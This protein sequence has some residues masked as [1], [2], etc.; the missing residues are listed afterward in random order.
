MNKHSI[1]NK[2]TT[3]NYKCILRVMRITVFLFFLS[4]MFSQASTSYSQAFS[5]NLSSKSIKEVCKEIERNS[6]YIFVFSDNS[7][8]MID[9][10]VDVNANAENVSEI[11]NDIFSN[12]R[13][14]YRILDKQIVVYESG[15]N[16]STRQIEHMTKQQPAKKQITGRV[17]DAQ[18]EAVIGANIIEVGTTTGTITDMNGNFTLNVTFEATIRISYI[19]YLE[20]VINTLDKK[21]FDIVLSEDDQA[22]DEVVILGFGQTQSKVSQTGSIVSIGTK[23]LKQSPVANITNALAGRL[24]GLITIQ[25]SGEPGA[26]NASLFVRGR[27]SLNSTA[28]LVTIDGIQRDSRAIALLDVN[29]IESITILKD[30]S[31][32]AIYGIKGANG[33]IIVTTRTG[34]EGRPTVT[35]SVDQSVQS[36]LKLPKFLN[37]FDNAM[38]ANEAFM[39]DNPNGEPIF[40]AKAIE[41]YRTGT[42]PI[43]YPNVNW[44]DELIKPAPQ[45]KVNFNISGGSPYV[46]YFLNFG[47]LD[48]G[49]IYNATKNS[50][51]DPNA[52]YK[53]YNFRSNV[54]VDYDDNFSVGLKLNA[55]IEN[56]N[57][58]VYNSGDLF[59]TALQLPPHEFPIKYPTGYYAYTGRVEN[60]FWLLNESG[61]IESFNSLVSGTFTITRKLN[62]ITQGLSIRG[63]YS[64]DG[65]YNNGL[66]RNK[67]VPYAMYKG[68]GDYADYNSYTY[69]RNDNALSPPISNFTQSRDIWSDISLNYNRQFGDHETSG[70][71]LANRTQKVIGNDVPF[72]SQG[73]V[74][75]ALYNFHKRYFFEF[76]AGLNGS[77]NFSPKKRYGFFPSASAGWVLSRENFMNKL[78][79]V[80]F[81]KVRGSYGLT[82][83]DQLAGRRWLYYSEFK[84]TQGYYFGQS[85]QYI[86]G[87]AEGAMSNPDV[88]WEKARKMNIGIELKVL[89]NLFG[90]TFDVFN[91]NRY[92]ILIT[93]NSVPTIIGVP[94]GNLPPANMGKVRDKG[95]E[96]ELSHNNRINTLIY[97]LNGN[98]SFARNKIIFMDEATMPYHWLQRTGNRI[99]Q[100]FALTSIGFFNDETDIQNSPE[101]FGVLIP[102]DLKYKDLD[103]NGII[104]GNDQSPVGHSTVPEIYYG[105]SG[106]LNWK[107][108]DLSFLIQGIGNTT[109]QANRVGAF[110][111]VEGG[112][113]NEHHLGRWTPETAETATYPA[114]HYGGNSNNH[115]LSTFFLEDN[116]YIRLKNVE[117][118]Y[119]FKNPRLFKSDSI[120][121]IRIYFSGMN[122]ITWTN[123]KLF[124]PENTGMS[125]LYPVMRIINGGISMNF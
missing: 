112:K 114:L 88:T 123:A 22:L 98:L 23:E 11:L 102:G 94:I 118:G 96:L 3:N 59:W 72:V 57:H 14:A 60:P 8:K 46:K 89:N 41:A 105:I 108:F 115:R 66:R 76:N 111:F 19:G 93:R 24:P 104:N 71:L 90:L 2:K 34:K 58:S 35:M 51:Y 37:A 6:D 64:F 119:T 43:K 21:N 116:S 47:Y 4:I 68:E 78:S 31:A 54:D 85:Q 73:L 86:G 12:T 124:D 79:F 77:D 67:Q 120:S 36:V 56:K 55:S 45:T 125:H 52:T 32:T 84:E 1:G 63:N 25:S 26:D 121:S 13:L 49:G 109:R 69:I 103:N 122:L 38:L 9:E 75:R 81:L 99:G 30:A 39:N 117:L 5:F 100:H 33:V 83:N 80:D 18:G 65:Y 10:K 107:N 15:E 53:R 62:F 27:A 61:Y 17:V 95:F 16:L 44:L 28:P 82:G 48:Q 70:L 29:E 92:D 91:E 20:Q 101:Q 42:D 74:M 97:F 110:E 87:Y 113:V 7:E 106:G 40:S 50:D